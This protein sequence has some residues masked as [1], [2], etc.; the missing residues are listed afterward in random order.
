MP[1]RLRPLVRSR[2]RVPAGCRAYH[3]AVTP[4]RATAHVH[5]ARLLLEQGA[6]ALAPGAAVTVALCGTWEHDGRC[7]WP[8]RT[9]VVQQTGADLVVRVVF[10]CPPAEE[11]NLRSR[12]VA[13]LATGRLAGPVGESRWT[14]TGEVAGRL[15]A[16]EQTVGDRLLAS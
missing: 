1:P 7:R 8:H 6:D 2:A 16:E 9:S 11:P 12:I 13:A 10:A 5:E 3:R 15:S 4:A 14:L